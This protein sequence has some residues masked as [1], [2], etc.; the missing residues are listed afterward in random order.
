MWAALT[1][2]LILGV[3]GTSLANR[4]LYGHANPWSAPERLDYCNARFYRYDAGPHT[5]MLGDGAVLTKAQALSI[6]G[7]TTL[8]AHGGTGL[9][10]QWQVFLP[11]NLKCPQD[12][13]NDQLAGFMFISLGP[14][15]YLELT[16]AD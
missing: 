11:G 7:S 5:A 14:D 4:Y 9:F 6:S 2:V 13:V 16:D 12:P 1:A 8:I 3:G 15:R 10:G